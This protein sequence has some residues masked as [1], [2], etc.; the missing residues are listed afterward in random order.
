MSEALLRV[1]GVGKSFGGL[2]ALSDVTFEVRPG[3]TLAV[4]GP[5]GAGKST[6]FN[7][8]TGFHRPTTG[9]VFFGGIDLTMAPVHRI[10]RA[11]VGRTFQKIRLFKGL[12][13]LEN[14]RMAIRVPVSG[15]DVLFRSKRFNASEQE[16]KDGARK[17]LDLVGLSERADDKA[18][19]LPYGRQRLLEIARALAGNPRLLLLDE[20]G[21]GMNTQELASL[22][23]LIVRIRREFQVTV[24]LVEHNVDFV[25]GLS[26]RIVVLDHGVTIASGA[27]NE[28]VNNPAVIEAY[29]GRPHHD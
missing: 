16:A 29:L 1:E 21:A 8:L 17:L 28:V 6:L 7:I 5:N 3:E 19:S 10:A 27:P 14:V 13:V 15:L 4:I 24:L 12:T 2:K 23:A 11:G 18:A 22:Q 9:H 26:D 25:L 20:P